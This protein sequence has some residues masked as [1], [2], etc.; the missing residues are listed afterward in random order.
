MPASVLDTEIKWGDDRL[1]HCSH[2][3]CILGQIETGKKQSFRLSLN[4]V[5]DA[6]YKGEVNATMR[7]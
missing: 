7:D 3:N 4:C 6:C 1:S 2:G 5:C